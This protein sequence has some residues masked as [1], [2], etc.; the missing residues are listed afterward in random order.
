MEQIACQIDD[1]QMN[2]LQD[3]VKE[4]Y[5]D[6]TSYLHDIDYFTKRAILSTKNDIAHNINKYILDVI[7]GDEVIYY[8]SDS[9]S[10]IEGDILDQNILYPTE[11]LNTL[12]FRGSPNCE[13]Q[14]KIGISVMLL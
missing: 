6:I 7:E 12:K 1:S 14:L 4:I 2:D 10:K 11:Y 3:M 13:L 9:I 8:S 5:S